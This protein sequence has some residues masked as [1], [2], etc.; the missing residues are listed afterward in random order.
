M[1]TLED[2]EDRLPVD[3]WGQ[4]V[5]YHR[6]LPSTNN[7]AWEL[8]QDGA[9]H[10]TLVVA[11][12]QTAGK[13]R[14]GNR[15]F[16]PPDA[17]LAMSVV[18]RPEEQAGVSSGA[19]SVLGALAVVEAVHGIG[20]QA[21]IKWPNDVLIEGRKVCGVLSEASWQA[22]QLEFAVVGIGVNI[23]P[24]SV[25]PLEAVQ[26]PAAC[27]E[28]LRGQPVRRMDLLLD[29][30]RH[31]AKWYSRLGQ[32]ALADRWERCLAYI[33]ESVRLQNDERVVEGTVEGLDLYGR[34]VV[35]TPNGIERLVSGAWQFSR[36]D[37][38]EN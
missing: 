33:G 25:P 26:W 11:N 37:R 32:P 38:F 24:E 6:S 14:G 23:R 16:T 2:L 4:V 19:L 3:E 34:L 8:A 7:R 31:M 12:E 36:V 35:Q 5:E 22:E 28:T 10:G 15:W 20:L 30:V 29:I 17:A 13:G 1:L 27:L 9:P 18:V 21:R